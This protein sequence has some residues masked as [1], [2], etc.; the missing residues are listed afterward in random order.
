MRF[1]RISLILGIASAFAIAP[2]AA[3]ARVNFSGQGYYVTDNDSM[4][5]P[6]PADGEY[7]SG[8][9]A[10]QADCNANLPQDENAWCNYYFTGDPDPDQIPP[11]PGPG[12]YIRYYN[13]EIDG[14][15]RY[16]DQGACEQAMSALGTLP[17]EVSKEMSCDYVDSDPGKL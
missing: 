11:W 3:D 2:L 7:Q 5:I 4:D 1:T 13:N 9:F 14:L 15:G 8:P 6:R 10:T 17:P 16:D 12:Y